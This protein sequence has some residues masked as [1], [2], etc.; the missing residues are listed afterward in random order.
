MLYDGALRFL[1]EAKAAQAVGDLPRRAHALHRVAA[2]LAECHSTLDL[3]RGGPVAAELDRLY[4]YMSTRLID[5]TVKRD[6]TAID[7]IHTLMTP[8]RNAW[9]EAATQGVITASAAATPPTAA[10]HVAARP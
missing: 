6:A 3:E 1:S 5:V 4:S 10:G 2:I 8:L 7:E 9:S